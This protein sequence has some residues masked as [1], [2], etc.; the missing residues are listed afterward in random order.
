MGD[1]VHHRIEGARPVEFFDPDLR[2]RDIKSIVAFRITR[3][4]GMQQLFGF[5]VS[6]GIEARPSRLEGTGSGQG[7]GIHGRPHRLF[8]HE[9][10]EAL[11]H[12]RSGHNMSIGGLL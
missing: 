5:L 9:S 1:G 12:V 11:R 4:D 10:I 6:T 7:L 8:R 2:L 3:H